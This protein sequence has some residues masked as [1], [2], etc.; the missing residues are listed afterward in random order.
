[1]K[2]QKHIFA[3]LDKSNFEVPEQELF[4][5]IV[6]R[7][8]ADASTPNQKLLAWEAMDFLFSD[9]IN[10]Y[11]EYINVDPEVFKQGLKRMARA[12]LTGPAARGDVGRRT[13]GINYNLFYGKPFQC[14]VHRDVIYGERT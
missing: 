14:T 8:I 5:H 2:H 3:E 12:K 7:A 4:Y 11:L 10:P 9:R 6:H 13:F 1:M